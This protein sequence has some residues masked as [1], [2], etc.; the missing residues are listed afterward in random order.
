MIAFIF[1]FSPLFA[2]WLL[3]LGRAIDRQGKMQYVVGHR[4][5]HFPAHGFQKIEDLV[6]A[7]G[8]V[9]AAGK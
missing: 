8:K 2:G 3:L 9:M 6:D 5:L 1:P 7:A 4:G